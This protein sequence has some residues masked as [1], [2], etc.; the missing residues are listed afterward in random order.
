M[1]LFDVDD[2]G[3]GVT[4]AAM[5]AQLEAWQAAGRAVGPITRRALLDQATAI[6]LAR[7]QRRPTAITGGV[8][9]LLTLLQ[10]FRLVDDT[11]PPPDDPFDRLL[12]ELKAGGPTS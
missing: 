4:S 9:A 12:D 3:D 8:G 11:P 5:S 2:G 6:D 7:A 1:A 10:G